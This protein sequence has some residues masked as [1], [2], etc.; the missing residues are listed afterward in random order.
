MVALTDPAVGSGDLVDLIL[1]EADELKVGTGSR[2]GIH[3]I[4][5]GI[6]TK[7]DGHVHQAVLHGLKRLAHGNIL[8]V[9]VIERHADGV[10]DQRIRG[11]VAAAGQTDAHTL[12]AGRQQGSDYPRSCGR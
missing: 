7:D 4:G 6:L 3:N 8:R 2:H 5:V 12:A 9:K 10:E 1:R 11:H